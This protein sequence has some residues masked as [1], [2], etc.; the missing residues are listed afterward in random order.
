MKSNA[1][2]ACQ[3]KKSYSTQGEALIVV[4]YLWKE[5]QVEVE[6]YRCSICETWHLTS[7]K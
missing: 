7:K 5:K 6:P 2:V 3:S 4:E 1:I